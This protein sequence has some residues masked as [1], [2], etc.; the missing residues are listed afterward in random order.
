MRDM[1]GQHRRAAL[2]CRRQGVGADGFQNLNLVAHHA[3]AMHLV[4]FRDD[5]IALGL[6]IGNAAHGD[7][8]A[9]NTGVNPMDCPIGHPRCRRCNLIFHGLGLVVRPPNPK[10][11]HTGN[12]HTGPKRFAH[13]LPP[14]SVARKKPGVVGHNKGKRRETFAKN[15]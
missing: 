1:P 15:A 3:A 11:G 6:A 9:R 5:R 10:T 7:V 12:K 8:T 14:C 13:G 4:Q 2:T